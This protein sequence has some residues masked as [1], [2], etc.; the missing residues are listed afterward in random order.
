MSVLNLTSNITF[1]YHEDLAAV[2]K[3]YEETLGLELVF[4]PGWACVFRLNEKSFIGAV[5]AGSGSIKVESRGGVLI[6]LTV[7]NIEEVHTQLNGAFGVTNLSEIKKVKDI[8]LKSFFFEGPDGYK[9]EIQQFTSGEL[10][11]LF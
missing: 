10:Q 9:Y 6:S 8:S 1:L 7:N 3:F 2:R 5:D 4:N 11:E